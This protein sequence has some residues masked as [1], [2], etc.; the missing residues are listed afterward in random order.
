MKSS[1]RKAYL[2]NLLG[3]VKFAEKQLEKIKAKLN[4]RNSSELTRHATQWVLE[5]G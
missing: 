5:G 3:E 4:L 1:K 2:A